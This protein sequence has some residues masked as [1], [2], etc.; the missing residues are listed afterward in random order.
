MNFSAD[1]HFIYITTRDD[2]HKKQL[3][4]YYKLTEEDLEEI[5]KEWL[6][7]LLIPSNPMELSDV[8]SPEATQDTPRPR[9]MKN[10]E[11]VHD[12]DITSMRTS[13]ILLD[14]GGDGEDIEGE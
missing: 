7:D 10:P 11:E 14:E 8:D 5:T 6:V 13:S 12:A 2:E 1:R 9:K 3:Q 4:S